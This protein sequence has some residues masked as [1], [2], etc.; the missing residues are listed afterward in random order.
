MNLEYSSYSDNLLNDHH[1]A[2][3]MQTDKPLI[4]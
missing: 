3:Q 1:T 2:T 4:C